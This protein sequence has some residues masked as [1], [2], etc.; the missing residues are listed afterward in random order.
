M[1]NRV[2]T[3]MKLLSLLCGSK[4]PEPSLIDVGSWKDEENNIHT[5]VYS[6]TDGD[7][8][9]IKFHLGKIYG[10]FV[11]DEMTKNFW[12]ELIDNFEVKHDIDF[13]M[14]ISFIYMTNQCSD[15][16]IK[17]MGQIAHVLMYECQ[18]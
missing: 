16:S 15:R 2:Q 12:K 14:L 4:E 6:L 1:I 18:R 3:E 7:V 5:F 13:F 11:S 17:C 10:T 8:G 9:Q